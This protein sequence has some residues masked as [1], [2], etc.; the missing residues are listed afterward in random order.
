MAQIATYLPEAMIIGIGPDL[1]IFD[2]NR[3]VSFGYFF[4]EYTHYLHNIST[5]SGIAA[6]INTIELWRC[7]RL[8]M[9]PAGYSSGSAAFPSDR[10]AYLADLLS[11][12]GRDSSGIDVLGC[13]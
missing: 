8:T 4:H 11:A 3:R 2:E 6:F 13:R 9:N 12:A 1:K 10:K 7:F 5:A